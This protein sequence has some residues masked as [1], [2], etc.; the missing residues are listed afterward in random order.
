MHEKSEPK[1]AHITYHRQ[2]W[3]V[4]SG[5]SVQQTLPEIGIDPDHVVVLRHQ[6]VLASNALIEPGDEIKLVNVVAGG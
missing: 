3:Y 6:R 4:E 1:K 2:E 5:R